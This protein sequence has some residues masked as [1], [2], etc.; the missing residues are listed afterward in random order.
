MLT[1]LWSL[2]IHFNSLIC[3]ILH[4]LNGGLV[5]QNISFNKCS[6]LFSLILNS[7]SLS[8]SI[9]RIHFDGT[10]SN[11]YDFCYQWLFTDEN[12]LAFPNLKSLIFTRCGS[13][14]SVFHC[15]NS[16][17]EHQ[18]DEL[19]LK[20]D[21]QVFVQILYAKRYSRIVSDIGKSF[22]YLYS[23]IREN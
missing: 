8:S 9:Q 4:C 18:L 16:L 22:A 6:R 19:T 20:F 5:T 3:S 14:K 1:S 2:N 7:S 11:G 21:E 12:I 17:I 23:A 13:I 15:L 10:N